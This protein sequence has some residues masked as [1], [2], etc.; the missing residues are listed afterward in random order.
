MSILNNLSKFTMRLVYITHR[1][2]IEVDC[3]TRISLQNIHFNKTR[4]LVVG[5][6]QNKHPWLP[7]QPVCLSAL[8]A[9]LPCQ[10]LCL[11][12]LSALSACLASLHCQPVCLYGLRALFCGYYM[13]LLFEVFCSSPWTN[14]SWQDEPWTEFSTL[15]G[16]ACMPCTYWAVWQYDLT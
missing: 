16:S 15:E 11:V 9:S 7:C 13:H 3:S 1:Y 12:S 10:P 8:S 6:K 5:T 14:F 4:A 2:L